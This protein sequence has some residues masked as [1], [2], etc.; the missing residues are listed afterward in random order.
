MSIGQ[1]GSNYDIEKSFS[2]VC[3]SFIHHFTAVLF[4]N[5][6][7][8]KQ[9][10]VFGPQ[11]VTGHCVTVGILQKLASGPGALPWGLRSRYGVVWL[12]DDKTRRD[13]TEWVTEHNVNKTVNHS[14]VCEN[15]C[16]LLQRQ[17]LNHTGGSDGEDN[18]SH[19]SAPIDW[20]APSGSTLSV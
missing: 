18:N 11:C 4:H 7:S 2:G 10:R 3:D 6:S 13:V 14:P 16:P 8:W 12:S 20:E 19:D 1:N 17:I 15:F 9:K 5:V